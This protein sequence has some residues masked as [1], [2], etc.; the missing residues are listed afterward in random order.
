MAQEDLM[1]RVFIQGLCFTI[2]PSVRK[3][4]KRKLEKKL[5]TL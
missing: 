3:D 1:Q 4:G 5:L 2:K